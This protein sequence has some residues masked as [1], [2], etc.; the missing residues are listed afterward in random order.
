MRQAGLDPAIR[1]VT[2]AHRDLS[3]GEVQAFDWQKDRQEEMRIQGDDCDGRV[4][5]PVLDG[6]GLESSEKHVELQHA[7]QHSQRI[8]PGFLRVIDVER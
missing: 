4:K 3:T 7:D 8:E 6:A 1:S 5:H 2:H